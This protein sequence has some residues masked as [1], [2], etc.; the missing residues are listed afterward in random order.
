MVRFL[1]LLIVATLFGGMMLYSF[2]FAPLVFEILK[3]EQASDLLREAF[4]WYYLLIIIGATIGAAL[5]LALDRGSALV[6]VAIAIL[7][8][9]AR[10]DLMPRISS[11]RDAQLVGN[12]SSFTPLHAA[13]VAL[14]SLQMIGL[15]FVLFRFL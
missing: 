7:A 8:L 13:S 3:A 15:G 5:L 2:G 4:P 10:Q 6:M 12:Q 9:Y 14:N 1:A 11:A